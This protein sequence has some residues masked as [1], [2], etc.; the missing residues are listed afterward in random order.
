MIWSSFGRRLVASADAAF[1][2]LA[3]GLGSA[4][5]LSEATGNWTPVLTFATPGDLAVTY[6]LQAGTYTKIGRQ[7]TLHFNVS[8]ASFTHT[9]AAG[10][11]N[12][13]G[14]PFT[15]SASG[16]RHGALLWGGITK[17]G[18]TNMVCQ[19]AVSTATI[20]VRGSGSGVAPSTVVAADV[21]TGGTVVLQGTIVFE[22]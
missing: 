13:T 15:N 22:V 6:T 20:A 3:L 21:P 4:A 10:N 5:L 8:T 9:T 1:A 17:A 7:V 12:I 11:L 18:Y 16:A 19:M 14:S 2:R